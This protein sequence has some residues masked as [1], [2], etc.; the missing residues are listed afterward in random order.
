MGEGASS[1]RTHIRSFTDSQKDVE[2][3]VCWLNA[4]PLVQRYSPSSQRENSGGNGSGD[5]RLEPSRA[6]GAGGQDCGAFYLLEWGFPQILFNILTLPWQRL[7]FS[8]RYNLQTRTSALDRSPPTKVRDGSQRVPRPAPHAQF[9][10]APLPYA[11]V[12]LWCPLCFDAGSTQSPPFGAD[13]H[14]TLGFKQNTL[15]NITSL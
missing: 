8:L 14:K 10:H 4:N 7:D 1:R 15:G 9:P 13:P 11:S 12:T 3:F 6:D 5:F 2:S